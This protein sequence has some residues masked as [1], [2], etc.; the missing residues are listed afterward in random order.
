MIKQQSERL[1]PEERRILEVASVVGAEFSAAAVAAGVGTE[2]EE[3][4]EQCGELARRERFLRAAGTEEWPDGT[5]AATV[6]SLC[7]TSCGSRSVFSQ[8]LEI[9][10]RQQAKS[11]ELRA[12]VSLARLWQ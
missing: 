6:A 1:T 4:E 10:R 3:V 7:G 8:S 12:T 11:L 5:G 2:I 9:S